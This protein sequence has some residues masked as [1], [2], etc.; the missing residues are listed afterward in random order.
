MAKLHEELIQVNNLK[1]YFRIS[2]KSVLKAVDDVSFSI[3]K[4]ETLGLVGESGCGKS[5]CGRTVV[6]LYDATGGSVLYEGKDVHRLKK[7]ENCNLRKCSIYICR[8]YASLDPRMTIGDII[9][10]EWMSI[11]CI[12]MKRTQFENP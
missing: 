4:G 3:K 5:T 6:G 12:L 8:P 1:K 9:E 2:R 7:D 10:R 11:K